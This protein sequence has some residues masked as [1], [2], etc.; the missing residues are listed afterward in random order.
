MMLEPH[1]RE[2]PSPTHRVLFL[3]VC[4]GLLGMTLATACR[5]TVVD[6]DLFHEM[7]LFREMLS[8]G[9]MPLEDSYAYTPRINPVVHHEW[10]TG[11]ILYLVTVASGLGASGLMILKYSLSF[12]LGLGCFV[13]ARRR[14]GGLPVFAFLTPIALTL[15]WVGFSTVRAQLFTLVCL[16]L[17]FFFLN[18]DRRGRR[19][20]IWAWLPMEVVWVNL[21][22]G[23]AA[24]LGILG[25]YCFDQFVDAWRNLG[26]LGQ[27]VRR[28]RHLIFAGVASLLMLNVTPYGF[29]Y[30]P[31]LVRAIRM[32]RPLIHE[33][34]P[35]WQT[36]HWTTLLLY[37]CSVLVGMYVIWRRGPWPIFEPLALLLTAWLA[38]WHLR[39]LSIYAV[40]WICLVPAMVETTELGSQIKKLWRTFPIP[41]IVLWSLLGILSV[42][43]SIHKE[44]WRLEIP[45]APSHAPPGAPVYPAGAVQY[46]KEKGFHGNLMVPFDVGA[47][48]SWHLY[49]DV[50]VSNDS[51]Y[52][53]AYPHG[54]VE[55]I[56]TLYRAEPGWHATLDR[57]PPDAILVPRGC[58][59]DLALEEDQ[60][61]NRLGGWKCVYRDSGYL[62]Y[63]PESQCANFPMVDRS[64]EIIE[65]Y[66]P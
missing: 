38:A 51:R 48:V 6:L 66:F 39:H 37:V 34:L 50:K 7:A 9:R 31:Y 63:M 10:G 19:W 55:E 25:I 61:A 11:G 59:L 14:G 23:V 1:P 5:V 24:G 40:T 28:T 16:V 58:P 2:A 26:S 22:G 54:L 12:T 60:K 33:W 56:V 20:W 62:L 36:A 43:Y 53:V 18:E 47:F 57:Y 27:A 45:T 65:T 13:N 15:G 21:H 42:G 32:E 49:P 29:D 3:A 41:L 17:L 52:E 30:V 46:L 44:F 4:F 8:L 35:I 64:E